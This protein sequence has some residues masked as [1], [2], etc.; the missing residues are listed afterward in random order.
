M[1]KYK[2][3]EEIIFSM[4]KKRVKEVKSVLKQ[5]NNDKIRFRGVVYESIIDWL[6]YWALG[7][8]EDTYYRAKRL[9]ISGS[10]PAE[11]FLFFDIGNIEYHYYDWFDGAER[12]LNGDDYETMNELYNIIKQIKERR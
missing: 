11:C 7:F 12:A 3:C 10:E 9:I 4:L 2:S 6:N 8:K 5:V 1:K